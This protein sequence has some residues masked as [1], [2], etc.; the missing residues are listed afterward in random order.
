MRTSS[1]VLTFFTVALTL[2]L[3]I[4]SNRR[5]DWLTVTSPE[6]LNTVITVYYGLYQ[7]CD[8]TVTRIPNRSGHGGLEYTDYTC[9][10]FPQPESDRC[11]DKNR[12]FCAEWTTARYVSELAMG[13][14]AVALFAILFGVTTRS[15]RRRIWKTVAV[16]LFFHA[17]LQIAAFGLITDLYRTSRQPSFDQARPG[18]AYV[19]NTV[20]WVVGVFLT[21][22]VIITGIAADNGH[23]WAAGHRP[24]QPILG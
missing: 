18:I 1:Y 19:A 17:T 10:S 13:F 7:T 22:T 8:W 9:R 23:S 20:S 15:R 16:L 2:G 24:Y 12:T 21:F 6:V 4:L 14:G 3:N 5:V 11:D